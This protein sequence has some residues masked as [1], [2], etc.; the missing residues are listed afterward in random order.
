[1][2]ASSRDRTF[3][4]R[5]RNS[6]PNLPVRRRPHHQS[7]PVDSAN[8]SY[9][10][11]ARAALNSLTLRTSRL[12]KQ[13]EMADL[14]HQI[15]EVLDR[16]KHDLL[17]SASMSDEE[18][19]AVVRQLTDLVARLEEERFQV[20]ERRFEAEVRLCFQQARRTFVD[21]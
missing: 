1:M 12:L 3:R 10:S 2:R 5:D 11:S 18:R 20:E 19:A 13:C 21:F 9:A 14:D 6:P 4:R 15:H 7:C 16:R 8:Q 17:E